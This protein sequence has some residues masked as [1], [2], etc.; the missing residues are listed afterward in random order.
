[1]R[2]KAVIRSMVSGSVRS[3]GSVSG[4]APSDWIPEVWFTELV[5]PDIFPIRGTGNIICDWIGD[6]QPSL[7]LE[8]S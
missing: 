2:G 4:N 7:F 3:L 6:V 5:D 8:V 1:M